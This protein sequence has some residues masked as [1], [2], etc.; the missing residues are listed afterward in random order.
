MERGMLQINV[1]DLV[2]HKFTMSHERVTQSLTWRP[3]LLFT[4]LVLCKQN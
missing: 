3:I 4:Y 1:S 2:H